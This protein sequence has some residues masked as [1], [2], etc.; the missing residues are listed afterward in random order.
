MVRKNELGVGVGA[1]YGDYQGLS[2]S[3]QLDSTVEADA[4]SLE[5]EDDSV[6][7]LASGWWLLQQVGIGFV[8]LR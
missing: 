4:V 1:D 6:G 5:K 3:S 2:P 8:L 7:P